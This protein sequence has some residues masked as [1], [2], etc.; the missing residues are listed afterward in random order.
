MRSDM[1]SCGQVDKIKRHGLAMMDK[2]ASVTIEAVKCAQ[3][4]WCR[5]TNATVKSKR[6]CG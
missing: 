3:R 5:W 4:A 1:M 2:V 6:S